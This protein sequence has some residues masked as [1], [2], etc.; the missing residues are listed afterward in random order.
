[1]ATIYLCSK[2]TLK[3]RKNRV[4][5]KGLRGV[6]LSTNYGRFPPTER[7]NSTLLYVCSLHPE[8]G[9]SEIITL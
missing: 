7:K 3:V 2:C 8:T 9:L 4:G 6:Q 1:M 5:G